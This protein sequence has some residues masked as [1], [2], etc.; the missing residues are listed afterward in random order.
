MAEL[1]PYERGTAKLVA[2]LLFGV[3]CCVMV[4]LWFS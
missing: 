1:Y 4:F 3:L 2:V